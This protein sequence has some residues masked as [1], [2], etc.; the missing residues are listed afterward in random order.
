[1]ASSEY[2]KTAF[3]GRLLKSGLSGTGR[4]AQL[5]GQAVVSPRAVGK[6][7]VEGA[8][9]GL[10]GLGVLGFGAHQAAKGL[11]S[12]YDKMREP[13]R[14]IQD[15]RR[16]AHQADPLGT[17]AE[18][19]RG[20]PI[21]THKTAT[22]FAEVPMSKV[23]DEVYVAGALGV[24][25]EEEVLH[26]ENFATQLNKT[27]AISPEVKNAVT[28]GLI[29]AATTAAGSLAMVGAAK[30]MGNVYDAMTLDKD[31]QKILKVRP[32][33]NTYPKEQ[34]RLVYQ[35]LRRLSPEIA[36]D[37]LTASTYLV[38]QF[39]RRN[40]NDPHSLPTVELETAR[41]L[42][43]T[44]GEYSKRRDAVRDALL[45]ANRIG[46]STGLSHLQTERQNAFTTAQEARRRQDALE[47][48][49]RQADIAGHPGP[50]SGRRTP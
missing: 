37:P 43:Q 10:A 23:S 50:L 33:L 40:P 1:M 9:T 15:M 39:E 47:R 36:K 11:E 35:S 32:E 13:A 4:A 25:S 12:G 48:E 34:V 45:D 16:E 21:I 44:T 3:V 8:V 14:R 31:L 18:L 24:L 2:E 17:F 29:S 46:T 20:G 19:T 7:G 30:G 5:L 42:A 22:A 27:A 26:L 28:M 6:S 41:T 38:R 49:Q